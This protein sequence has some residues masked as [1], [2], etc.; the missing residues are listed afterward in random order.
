MGFYQ[1]IISGLPNMF[2]NYSDKIKKYRYIHFYTSTIY[3]LILFLYSAS[4]DSFRFLRSLNDFLL[5]ILGGAFFIVI[6]QLLM[7]F[8][9]YITIQTLQELG[10]ND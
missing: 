7:L 6:P 9:Y 5:Y 4:N 1:F 8:Y 3:L 2:L 10:K